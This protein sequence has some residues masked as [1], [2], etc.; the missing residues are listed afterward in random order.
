MGKKL[1]SALSMGLVLMLA[2]PGAAQPA[3]TPQNFPT[4]LSLGSWTSPAGHLQGM[5]CD[6]E[7]NYL[8]GSFT[9]RLVKVDMHTGQVVASVTGL[10]AGGIY[11]GGAHL[12][13][14]A[15]YQGKVYGSLEYKAAEKFYVAVFDVSKMT[16]MDMDYKTSGVMTALYMDEVVKDYCADLGA[17]EHN[18]AADS[19]GHRFGCSGIDG[20]TF[21]PMPGDAS[22]KTYMLLAY[23]VY[24]NTKRQDNDYQ[25]FLAFD[26]DTFAPLPFDQNAPHTVAPA[27][28]AKLFAYTGNTT[29]GVQNLEYD[30]DTGDYW[31]IV[32]EGKKNGFPNHPVYLIDGSKAPEEKPLFLG[33]GAE[34]AGMTGLCL[35]LRE[36]GA[37]HQKS[38]VW[39]IAQ[40]P[41]VAD[42]GFVSLGGGMFYV[43]LSGK[44]GDSQYGKAA[45]FRADHTTGTFE[46]VE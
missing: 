3:E 26:P 40:M 31:L 39:S 43:A 32:Y 8:Y 18:N 25:V 11:G 46:R 19:M 34:Y 30:R 28:A 23:G 21:G 7:N 42:T 44:T 10:L 6:D 27:L 36:I 24:G 37:Y 33:D 13:D 41:G 15:F 2:G 22:G 1:F 45:L 9:D 12:G 14:L 4:L 38:G 35:T 17:G 29:Y 20:I 5:V 16:E